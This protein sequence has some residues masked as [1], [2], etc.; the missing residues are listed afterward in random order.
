[1]LCNVGCGVDQPGLAF[2]CLDP[3]RRPVRGKEF[4][5]A[6]LRSTQNDG[7]TYRREAVC[8]SWLRKEQKQTGQGV[9]DLKKG[10]DIILDIHARNELGEKE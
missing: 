3:T 10:Y 6:G 5:R 8:L 9:V 7:N 4:R 2:C 1:M